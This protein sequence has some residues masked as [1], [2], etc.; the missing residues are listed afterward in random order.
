MAS[1]PVLLSDALAGYRLTEQDAG[2]LLSA[3]GRDVWR[4]TAAADEMR[5]GRIKVR[6]RSNQCPAIRSQPQ[7]AQ[8]S[9]VSSDFW[10]TAQST[11]NNSPA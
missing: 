10:S 4:V 5:F 8:P 6:K 9:N 3:R 11:G 2:V 7:S 1:V